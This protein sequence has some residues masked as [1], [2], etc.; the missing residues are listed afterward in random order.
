MFPPEEITEGQKR[1]AEQENRDIK[2]RG[3]QADTK[4]ADHIL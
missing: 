2:D 4:V 1:Q 3:G